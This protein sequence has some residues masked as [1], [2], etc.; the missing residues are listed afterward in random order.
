M[1]CGPPLPSPLPSPP[2][3]SPPLQT[4]LPWL[5]MNYQ[6]SK[7]EFVWVELS[8]ELC[9]F[10]NLCLHSTVTELLRVRGNTA[11]RTPATQV[12]N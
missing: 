7:D 11:L 12:L 4:G 2:L 10:L 8:G 6:V 3:P 5:H 1:I 9:V